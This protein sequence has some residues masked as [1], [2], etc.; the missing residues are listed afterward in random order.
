MRY[1]VNVKKNKR[2]K[3]KENTTTTHTDSLQYSQVIEEENERVRRRIPIPAQVFSISF[4]M[5]ERFYS[6]CPILKRKKETKRGKCYCHKY[7]SNRIINC[8]SAVTVRQ[9]KCKQNRMKLKS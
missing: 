9:K 2:K 6:C 3:Q 4:A 5:H 1:E 7:I 8:T